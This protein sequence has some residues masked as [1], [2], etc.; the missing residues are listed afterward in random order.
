MKNFFFLIL[1]VIL[2]F[3]SCKA[4]MS[5]TTGVEDVAYIKVLKS[6]GNPVDYDN[7]LFLIID[8]KK[9]L[10]S[11]I[12]KNKKRIKSDKTKLTVGKHHVVIK[13]KEE[14]LYDKQIFVGNQ[15][16]RKII[17]E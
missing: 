4:V 17:L 8:N 11:K 10:L 14:I 3:S 2:L 7:E 12:Y 16:T 1:G 15:E 6:D 9:V 5:E 13:Y